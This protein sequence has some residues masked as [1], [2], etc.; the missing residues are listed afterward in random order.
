MRLRHGIIPPA[1][2]LGYKNPI[3]IDCAEKGLNQLEHTKLWLGVAPML[4]SR[5]TYICKMDIDT[6]IVPRALKT[7]LKSL[8]PPS[9]WG[10]SCWVDP[11]LWGV[12][13]AST[14]MLCMH[15]RVW[16]SCAMLSHVFC[17]ICGGFYAL[18]YEVAF[19]LSH[20]ANNTALISLKS[21]FNDNEDRFVSHLI[22]R[23]YGGDFWFASDPERWQTYPDY[24]RTRAVVI[25]GIKTKSQWRS[26][27]KS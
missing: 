23:A 3:L 10:H 16:R 27:V 22:R 20:M 24:N 26:V 14:T 7:V 12:R 11:C 4:F 21:R 2:T 5:A 25:H 18:S 9:V 8:S 19:T 1:D 6:F 15:Q 13:P 17:G